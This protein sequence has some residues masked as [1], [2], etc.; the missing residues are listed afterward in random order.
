MSP[1]PTRQL[2]PG[3]NPL[4][5]LFSMRIAYISK[6]STTATLSTV[7]NKSTATLALRL[8]SQQTNLFYCLTLLGEIIRQ[9]V[10]SLEAELRFPVNTHSSTAPAG[11]VLC[12]K[13]DF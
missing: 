8:K 5:L 11:C 2:K 13:A 10:G 3:Q 12:Q 9:K 7:H 6:I 4:A 1:K